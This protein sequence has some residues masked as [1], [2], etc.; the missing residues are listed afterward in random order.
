MICEHRTTK[1]K[2]PWCNEFAA[3]TSPA[4]CRLCKVKGGEYIRDIFERRDGKKP[5]V[6][7]RPKK[8]TAPIK[9]IKNR[10][11]KAGSQALGRV[12]GGRK[13]SPEIL[14]EREKICRECKLMITDEIGE[15]CGELIA[16][17]FGRESKRKK[18]CGCL[19]NEKRLYRKFKCPRDKWPVAPADQKE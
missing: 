4:L 14:A 10:A 15:W 7:E 11:L 3:H 16:I 8:S 18:G 13:V 19:L 2:W 17:R 12:A 1:N 9:G 6:A 5:N